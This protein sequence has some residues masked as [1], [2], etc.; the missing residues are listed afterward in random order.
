MIFGQDCNHNFNSKI[1]TALR[2]L[3]LLRKVFGCLRAL[4]RP[5]YSA[6]ISQVNILSLIM[7]ECIRTST[8]KFR[9]LRSRSTWTTITLVDL[10][11]FCEAEKTRRRYIH[12]N[13]NKAMPLYSTTTC[14][15]KERKSVQIRNTFYEVA[16]C[17]GTQ[18]FTRYEYII[19]V[20]FKFGY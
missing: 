12:I 5:S 18:I 17:S 4:M 8:K 11:S 9:F 10:S 6:D 19:D 20:L 16:L 3:D 1:F 14:F 13:L 7:M 15:M 2:H